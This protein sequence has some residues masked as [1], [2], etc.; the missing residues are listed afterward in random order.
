MKS[1]KDLT[2][3]QKKKALAKAIDSKQQDLASGNNGKIFS[4]LSEKKKKELLDVSGSLCGCYSCLGKIKDLAAQDNELKEFIL[5]EA[6]LQA[7]QA[8][9]KESDETVFDVD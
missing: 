5:G 4:K 1:Y 6:L 2:Q 8:F 7:E 3:P 9:Y